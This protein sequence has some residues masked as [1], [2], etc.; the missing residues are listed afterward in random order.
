MHDDI[1]YDPIQGQ[2]HGA[3][4]V[5]KIALF[6]VYL[7]CHLLWELANNHQFLNYSTIS[8]F[9]WAGFFLYLS[10]FFC[11]VTL[12]LEEFVSSGLLLLMNCWSA[13]VF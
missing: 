5:P 9:N 1:L 3:S 11:H 6:E 8:K 12:N 2:G 10:Y 7:L 13:T 4:D